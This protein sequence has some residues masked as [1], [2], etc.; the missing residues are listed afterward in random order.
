VLAAFD[1]LE[2][3]S[4]AGPPLCGHTAE[5]PDCAL[6]AWAAAGPPARAERLA[7]SRRLLEAVGRLGPGS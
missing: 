3:A 2:V 7:S 5:D 4:R 6:D 1:D